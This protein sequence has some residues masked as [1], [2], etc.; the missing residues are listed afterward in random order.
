MLFVKRTDVLNNG[1]KYYDTTTQK[2]ETI[3]FY[4]YYNHLMWEHSP[5]EFKYETTLPSDE[6]T[7]TKKITVGKTSRRKLAIDKSRILFVTQNNCLASVSSEN[8]NNIAQYFQVRNGEIKDS[9]NITGLETEKF[10]Q[11]NIFILQLI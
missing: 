9:R 4:N 1:F 2:E 5:L 3:E 7:L 11:I 10:R 6:K 8:V